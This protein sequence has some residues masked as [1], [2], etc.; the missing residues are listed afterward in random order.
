[1]WALSTGGHLLKLRHRSVYR[2]SKVYILQWD[3]EWETKGMWLKVDPL[4]RGVSYP[5]NGRQASG[6]CV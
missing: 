4:T 2:R 6:A 3:I 1:M 5:P